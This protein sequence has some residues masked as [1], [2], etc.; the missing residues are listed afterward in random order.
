MCNGKP[1]VRERIRALLEE[2]KARGEHP[3][4]CKEVLDALGLPRGTWYY[5]QVRRAARE[6]GVPLPEASSRDKDLISRVESL[7]SR[8]EE[9]VQAVGLLGCDGANAAQ[10][11]SSVGIACRLEAAE[12]E[13][14]VALQLV[15]K[16]EREMEQLRERLRVLEHRVAELQREVERQSTELS[17]LRGGANASP[18]VLTADE[19]A[20]LQRLYAACTWGEGLDDSEL[21]PPERSTLRRLEELGLASCTTLLDSGTRRFVWRISER[22]RQVI[23]G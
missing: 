15:S 10:Q 21:L 17:R 3:L 11:G 8:V 18:V 16:Q 23:E 20:A 22:G 14:D 19:H 2:M 4:S 9:L 1:T 7:E 6:L 5:G 13:R 12:R